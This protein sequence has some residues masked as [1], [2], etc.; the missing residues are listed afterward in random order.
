[1]ARKP[2]YYNPGASYHV[3]LRGNN[4]Q[5]IFLNDE[6]RCRMCL[7]IKQGI[8]R[9]GHRIHAFC[10]MGNHIHLLLQVGEVSL[11]KIIHNLAFRY[12]Q[13]FNRRYKRKGHLFQGRFKAIII[14]ESAYFLRL[15]RYIHMNPVRAGLVKNPES[16]SWSAHKSY[17]GQMEFTWLTTDYGLVKFA[18]CLKQARLEYENYVLKKETEEEL[19]E[20]RQGFTDGQV[21]GDDNFLDDVMNLQTKTHDIGIPLE[22]ILKAICHIYDIDQ[23]AL[24]SSSQLRSLSLAR[25]ATVAFARQKGHTLEKVGQALNRDGSSL[26]RLKQGFM[27]RYAILI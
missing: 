19:K 1:M 18:D 4:G 9:Y 25:G 10:F 21:L 20:L 12:S 14:E 7:L 26:C 27:R 13:F 5:L 24:G 2:R 17:L 3:M 23:I 22:T 16:Y 6:D 11:S 15:L 8:E